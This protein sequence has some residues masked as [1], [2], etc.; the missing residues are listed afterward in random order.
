MSL[1]HPSIQSWLRVH[2][3]SRTKVHS[4]T[5]SGTREAFRGKWGAKR[6]TRKGRPIEA[7]F[8]FGSIL[9]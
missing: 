4:V 3:G 5:L 7:A 2:L 8:L 6:G 9:P 1:P